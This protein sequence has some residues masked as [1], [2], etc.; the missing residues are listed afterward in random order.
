TNLSA[1]RLDVTIPTLADVAAWLTETPS[2]RRVY[3]D[4]KLPAQSVSCGVLLRGSW[5][6]SRLRFALA[7]S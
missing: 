5:R 2:M 6:S 1:P 4:L 3:V 7:S